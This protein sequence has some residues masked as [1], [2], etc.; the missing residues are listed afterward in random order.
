MTSIWTFLPEGSAEPASPFVSQP[1]AA[2]APQ[3]S[4]PPTPPPSAT[5]AA[6]QEYQP[7][8]YRLPQDQ[9]QDVPPAS[10]G[11]FDFSEPHA[12]AATA[13]GSEDAF[14][15]KDLTFD[16]EPEQDTGPEIEISS[17]AAAEAEAS[18]ASSSLS[19]EDLHEITPGTPHP[20]FDQEPA[21]ELTVEP[22][23]EP[24]PEPAPVFSPQLQTKPAMET[25]FAGDKDPGESFAVPDGSE[26][27]VDDRETVPTPSLASSPREGT[28]PARKNGEHRRDEVH[29]LASGNATGAVAG[30]GC[31][32]PLILLMALGFGMMAKFAPFAAGLPLVHLLV[33][34]GTGI[35]SLSVMLGIIIALVQARAGKKLFFLVNILV[36]TIVGAGFGV[37]ESA[38][39]S[40]I[41]GSGLNLP[42]IITNA[43]G[44]ASVA[45]VLSVLVV[46]SRRLM[47]AAKDETFS[48]PLTGLQK[49]GLVIS[50]AV[51]LVAVYEVGS[52][53]GRMQRSAAMTY[54]RTPE[55]VTAAGLQVSNAQGYFEPGTGDLVITGTIRNTTDRPKAG[56]YLVAEILDD[57]ESVLTTAKMLSGIQLFTAADYE[58]LAKRG[59]NVEALRNALSAAETGIIPSGG[60]V[61]FELRVIGPPKGSTR[62]LPS[63]RTFDPSRLNG[64]VKAD[65]GR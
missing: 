12:A 15:E 17:E 60:S 7:Q 56:W 19:G 46:I 1:A 16:V 35:I 38:A 63:L 42:F 41:A 3:P 65:A 62:F 59:M 57:K 44:T 11:D 24:T 43:T 14:G 5:Q 53:A 34:V 30:L 50:L 54:Q 64:S 22:E 33:I 40:L 18:L 48:H 32:A 8:E 51:A 45:F 49:T 6:A 13:G 29:P 26:L 36:G 25:T 23:P 9:Q 10:L 39:L 4:V 58:I 28:S 47:I 2:P 27:G 52:F 20:G 37:G 21:L 61:D 31:A 55:I